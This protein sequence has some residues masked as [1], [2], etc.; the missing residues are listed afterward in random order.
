MLEV[1]FALCADCRS[2]TLQQIRK[3]FDHASS[4]FHEICIKYINLCNAVSVLLITNVK[5]VSVSAI[6]EYK[7]QLRTQN[8]KW[9]YSFP[10]FLF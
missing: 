7:H 10:L 2:F 4:K 8:L 5:Y 1:I 6:E 9:E 3:Y